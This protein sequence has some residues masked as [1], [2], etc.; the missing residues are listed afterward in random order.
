MSSK[1]SNQAQPRSQID[2]RSIES[3]WSS[4]INYYIS[5]TSGFTSSMIAN[6]TSI[7]YL[8]LIYFL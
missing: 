7:K 4:P 8:S 2:G 6:S 5:K 1:S 3:R